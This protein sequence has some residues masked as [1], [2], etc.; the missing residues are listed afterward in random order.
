MPDR[1]D[2]SDGTPLARLK[3]LWP[4]LLIGRRGL[5]SRIGRRALMAYQP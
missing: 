2:G 3:S 5:V 4:R 1:A